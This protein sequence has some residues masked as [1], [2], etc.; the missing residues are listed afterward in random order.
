MNLQKNEIMIKTENLKVVIKQL[1]DPK[2]ESFKETIDFLSEEY[3][4][5]PV[6]Y[7]TKDNNPV[8]DL[9]NNLVKN[10]YNFNKIEI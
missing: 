3:G 4:I 10:I 8:K 1:I 7:K 6:K 9:C 5:V 2:S